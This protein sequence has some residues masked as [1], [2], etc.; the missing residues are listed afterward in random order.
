MVAQWRVIQNHAAYS[1]R[2][3][4]TSPDSFD[5]K[6]NMIVDS[7]NRLDYYYYYYYYKCH[8]LECCQSHSYGA[9]YKNLDLNCC[10]GET[11]KL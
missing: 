3:T 6:I 7:A 5:A 11:E 9:L 4:R 10:T 2:R 1:V 8:R